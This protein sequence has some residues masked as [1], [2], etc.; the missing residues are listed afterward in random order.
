MNPTLYATIVKLVAAETGLLPA[1]QGRLAHGAFLDIIRQ[2]DPELS[3]TLH[4]EN[5]RKPFT[6]APLRGL[7]EAR[8]GYAKVR[9]GWEVSLRFTLLGNELFATFIR[10]FFDPSIFRQKSPWPTLRLGEVEFVFSEVLTS[11]GSDRW[12]GYTNL[13][14]LHQ[15][16]A[17]REI[18]IEFASPTAFSLSANGLGKRIE[19]VPTPKLLFGSL[20]AKWNAYL[21]P[22]LDQ[23]AIEKYAEKSVVVGQYQMRSQVYRYWQQPQLGAVG[24]MTYLLQDKSNEEMNRCLNMLAD[25]AFY[26]GVGYKTTMGMGQAR[27]VKLEHA[28]GR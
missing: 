6:V 21:E 3:A 2:V 26:A 9:Q 20:A 19:T 8:N 13:D 12:A 23:E 25:F 15:A 22:H 14:D 24:T 1:T 17:A 4:T 11:P 5:R 28:N 7:G 27:R 10:H 16:E 18:S